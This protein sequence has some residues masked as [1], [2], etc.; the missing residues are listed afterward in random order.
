MQERITY[1]IFAI[2]VLTLTAL[3]TDTYAQPSS[4]QIASAIENPVHIPDANLRTAVRQALRLAPE[5]VLD[6]AAMKQLTWLDA[7]ERDISDLTGLESATQLEYL[8]VYRNPI[9]NLSPIAS[10]VFLESIHAGA[11]DI[12]DVTPLGNLT[13]LEWLN[14]RH[15]RISDVSPL[16]KLPRLKFLVLNNNNISDVTPL[17]NLTSLERLHI[18]WNPVT[19]YTSLFGMGLSELL[20]DEICDLPPFP[21]SPRLR[22]RAYPAIFYAWGMPTAHNLVWGGPRFMKLHFKDM[23]TGSHLVGIMHDATALHEQ[24]SN[25]NPNVIL[26]AEVRMYTYPLDWFPDDWPHWLRDEHGNRFIGGGRA[27]VN[28]AHPEVQQHIIQRALAVSRC[29]LF[30]GIVFDHWHDDKYTDARLNILRD[31]RRQV[32]PDFIIIANTNDRIS[33]LTAPY[34]NGGFMETGVPG[35]IYI[36]ALDDGV[37]TSVAIANSLLHVTNVLKWNEEHMREPRLNCFEARYFLHE[38]PDSP[39][40]LRWMRAMTTLSLTHSDGYM[41][42]SRPG[43]HDHLWYEFWDADLG[44]PVEEK[45]QLY[46][47]DIPGL[48]V[49]EFTNG[50]AVYNHSGEGQVITLLEEV[51]GVA[52]GL[53]NTEHELPNLD[54]EMYLRIKP[55]NPADV[56]G[57]GVV[58][59]LDLVVV[60]QAFGKDDLQG[61]VNGDGV[62]NVFD[63]VFVANQF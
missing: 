19:D 28:Y 24:Y 58:N 14:L 54:G 26:L 32:S 15:N 3:C 1:T 44:R 7:D 6:R 51:Q 23:D 46:D 49:R 13:R 41:L 11:C 53:V 2:F 22:A 30:D 52:S 36:H 16:A 56:N 61:D 57:D 27:R 40:N 50:W 62:V 4:E 10:L 39:L 21:L 59:I 25:L 20:Y 47:E 42:F 37:D 5:E 55:A 48:Y 9:N 34:I 12:A 8:N 43:K 38:P 45:G 33:P 63:L 35:G 18:T 31:I 29:G 17:T 60:A